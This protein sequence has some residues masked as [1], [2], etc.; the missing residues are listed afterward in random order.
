MSVLDGFAL[1]VYLLYIQYT[2]IETELH[3]YGQVTVY[4][5][6]YHFHDEL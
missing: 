3:V 2:F 1:Q 5:P 4:S 6:S